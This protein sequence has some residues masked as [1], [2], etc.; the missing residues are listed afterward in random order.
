VEYWVID[1]D[2]RLS[3][4]GAL[5]DAS[6]GAEPEFVTPL[7]EIKTAPCET[8]A[9]LEAQLFRRIRR[10]LH[11]AD[12][13][14]KGLVPLATSLHRADV[15]QRPSTRTQIQNVVFGDTFQYVRHCAGTHFHFEQQ[16]GRTLDQLNTI[17]AL[18]PALALVNSARHFR[19]RDVAVGARS[20]LYRRMAY[21]GFAGQGELWPYASTA[22]AWSQRLA[23]CYDAFVERAV[24]A[25]VD[26][27][28]VESHY[29]PAL[30]ECAVW[31]PV[32][33]RTTF[34]TVEWRSPDTA[35]PSEVVRLA[36]AMA[37]VL[38]HL[39][40][41]AV[42]IGDGPGAVE[43]DVISLPPFDVVVD[44]VDTAIHEGL[45]SEALCAYLSRMGFDVDA[46][47]PFSHALPPNQ[48]MTLAEARQLRLE[49]ADRLRADV[50]QAP[51]IQAQ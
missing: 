20:K 16:P 34:G 31:A 29:D 9:E 37:A 7:L 43:D 17:I 8:A 3:E 44:H 2:G 19:G 25:G 15:A 4:P 10:V 35:L 33:L 30:P 24:A 6:V 46:F 41:T 38:E 36:H 49:H 12:E 27:S 23:D 50:L 48:P 14:G 11:R 42:R 5:T 45:S 51:S 22:E 26:R 47:S 40:T 39:Q 1:D 28:T 32:K 18:D 21:D 13:L